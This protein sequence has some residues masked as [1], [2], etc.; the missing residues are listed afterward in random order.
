MEGG[1]CGKNLTGWRRQTHLKADVEEA[2]KG[3]CFVDKVLAFFVLQIVGDPEVLKEL[4]KLHGK[5]E[6]N[7]LSSA[8]SLH[9]RH[10]VLDIPGDEEAKHAEAWTRMSGGGVEKC[11]NLTSGPIFVETHCEITVFRLAGTA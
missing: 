9:R 6:Q 4:E 5:E 8:G 1:D 7:A 11:G 2:C 10:L 3:E